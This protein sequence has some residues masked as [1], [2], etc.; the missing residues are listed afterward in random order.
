MN[1]PKIEFIAY[2]CILLYIYYIKY[3]FNLGIKTVLYLNYNRINGLWKSGTASVNM[4][5]QWSKQEAWFAC[6]TQVCNN[7]NTSITSCE[8]LR[9]SESIGRE[10][11]LGSCQSNLC[12]SWG[13]E[14]LQKNYNASLKDLFEN[15][16]IMKW[17]WVCVADL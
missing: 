11:E 13:Y 10:S 3:I 6:A 2:I 7:H 8:W 1:I 17:S 12:K 14:R 15:V 9:C 4:G 5:S 16:N